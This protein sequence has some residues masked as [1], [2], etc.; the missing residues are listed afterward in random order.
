MG[1]IGIEGSGIVG[2]RLVK[3]LGVSALFYLLIFSVGLFNWR[4]SLQ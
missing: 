3:L 1:R 4:Q 2:L